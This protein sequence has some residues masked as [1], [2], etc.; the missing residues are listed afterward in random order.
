MTT[1]SQFRQLTTQSGKKA[2]EA[3]IAVRD[4]NG[5]HVVLGAPTLGKLAALWKRMTGCEL[6]AHEAQHVYIV[7]A[8]DGAPPDANSV[9]DPRGASIPC[10]VEGC[11]EQ[12][13]FIIHSTGFCKRHRP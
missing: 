4:D 8:K 10:H 7:A 13:D 11:K 5:E 1:T 3:Y 2:F 9:R 12:A 6:I